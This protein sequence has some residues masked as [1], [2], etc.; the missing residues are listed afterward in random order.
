MQCRNNRLTN[1]YLGNI[2]SYIYTKIK[3]LPFSGKYLPGYDPNHGI[4]STVIDMIMG[5]FSVIVFLAFLVN[6][7]LFAVS[8]RS[9][10]AFCSILPESCPKPISFTVCYILPVVCVYHSYFPI[11]L[12]CFVIITYGLI[13]LPFALMEC[14][15]NRKWYIAS[16]ELRMPQTLLMEWRIIQIVQLQVN[17]LFGPTLIPLHTLFSKLFV[18]CTYVIIRKGDQMDDTMKLMFQMWAFLGVI[19]WAIILLFGG[20]VHLHGQKVLNS[21]KYHKWQNVPRRKKQIIRKFV[22]SCIPLTVCYG[23]TYVIRR[24]SVLKFFRQLSVG[25]L[26][27]L[28]AL[29]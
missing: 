22:K 25:V 21:W 2:I 14:H 29:D 11:I 27:T 4:V 5:L 19:V 13:F 9:P 3:W 12:Y 7:T 26:R 17:S 23:R 10:F 18:F 15:V 20:L 24:L 1:I 8:P 6:C 16:E 28:L